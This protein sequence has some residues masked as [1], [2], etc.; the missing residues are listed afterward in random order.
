MPTYEYQCDKGHRFELFQKMSDPKLKV[1][2][3]CGA[4]VERL[5]GPG[6]GIVFKGSG[7][8]ST[9]YR[10]SSYQKAAKSESGDGVSGKDKAPAEKGPAPKAEKKDKPPPKEPGGTGSGTSTPTKD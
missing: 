7:F 10:S 4:P 2:P 6:A 5:I 3:E 1:C 9:D 8:Y